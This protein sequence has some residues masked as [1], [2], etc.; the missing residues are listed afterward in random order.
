MCAQCRFAVSYST[1]DTAIV[2]PRSRPSGPFS[3]ESN[4]LNCTLGLC[5]LSTFVIAAVYVV[6]P[7]SMC[8]IV[9]MLTCGLL[10][11]NFS[12]AIVHSGFQLSDLGCRMENHHQPISE[13][14]TSI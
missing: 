6:L 14:L 13:I 8:P 5:L 2:T 12:F 3:I 4:A 10:R 7:W 11:S 9:P 1:C